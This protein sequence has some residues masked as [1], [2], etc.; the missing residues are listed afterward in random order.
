M[1]LRVWQQS[2][3]FSFFNVKTKYKAINH[4]ATLGGRNAFDMMVQFFK[5]FHEPVNTL[6]RV[7]RFLWIIEMIHRVCVCVCVY[8]SQCFAK[9]SLIKANKYRKN[10]IS[11]TISWERWR[12]L[13]FSVNEYIS[14][15]VS[16]LASSKRKHVFVLKQNNRKAFFRIS[17]A[18]IPNTFDI[19]HLQNILY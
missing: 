1:L 10:L 14:V 19:G 8:F 11:H 15:S 12:P 3:F 9:N 5:Y 16:L 18:L 7:C 6:M 17:N 4:A 2:N 13:L